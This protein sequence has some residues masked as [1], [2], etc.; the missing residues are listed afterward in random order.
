MFKKSG[1]SPAEDVYIVMDWNDVLPRAQKVRTARARLLS[2]ERA[3]CG[4]L[5]AGGALCWL[6]H[7]VLCRRALGMQHA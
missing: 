4:A 1:S 5:C 6:G 7:G 2:Q 3:A